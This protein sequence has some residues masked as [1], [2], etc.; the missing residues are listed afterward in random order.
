MLLRSPHLELESVR[1]QLQRC[2]ATHAEE[3]ASLTQRLRET[4]RELEA[5]RREEAWG[6]GEGGTRLDSRDSRGA[7][8]YDG[9]RLERR[10]ERLRSRLKSQLEQSNYLRVKLGTCPYS[11]PD[12]VYVTVRQIWSISLSARSGLFHCPP[13][14][15]YFT[16]RQIW[17]ISLSLLYCCTIM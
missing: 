6:G 11:L 5:A 17:S 15:V 3:V 2:Q 14:L 4:E 1:E 16:V 12:L 10:A 9:G 7:G 8:Q 13:D